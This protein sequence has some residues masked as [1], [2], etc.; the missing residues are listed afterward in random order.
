MQAHVVAHGRLDLEVLGL[1]AG[2][3]PEALLAGKLQLHAAPANLVAQPSVQGLEVDVLLRAE[4]AADV[5]L[6][7]ADAAP[8]DVER[9]A[10]DA[11]ADVRNLRGRD[12]GELAVLLVAVR[13]AHL[14]VGLALL[15]RE[16]V[17][18]E[19]VVPGVA[20][21]VLDAGVAHGLELVFRRHGEGVADDVV[22]LAL[23]H[24]RVRALH[25]LAR[26]VRDG[27]LLVLH[28]DLAERAV[29][30][31]L[32]LGDDGG[33]VVAVDAHAVVEQLAVCH[34]A[35]LCGGG[36]IPGVPRDGELGVG[37]VEAGEDGHDAR[38]CLR[39][40]HV[41][42]DDAAVSYGRVEDLG[43]EARLRAQVI[44]EHGA[45]G[46]LVTSVDALDL[47]SNLPVLLQF[48]LLS[49]KFSYGLKNVNSLL[50]ATHGW[51][52]RR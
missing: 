14:D 9:L 30:R 29:C 50:R 41:H 7:H 39:L 28:L 23:L 20:N 2:R 17:E 47:S 12:A 34:V 37:H 36:G 18:G 16:R 43:H 52:V 42:G 24:G 13:D 15:A 21:R 49:Y 3:V 5:G 8:G 10:D 11:P 4:T 32:V 6:D 25:G 22:R 44:R 31:D 51:R 33:N 46:D 27:I 38:D 35:L 48:L 45:T 40:R 1:A 19:V 26:V